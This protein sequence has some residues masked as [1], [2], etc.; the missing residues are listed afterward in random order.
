MNAPS[1]DIKDMLLAESDLGL[2][3]G[4]NLFI[5]KEKTDPDTIVIIYDTFGGMPDLTM[6]GQTFE[7]PSVQIKVRSRDYTI[8]YNLINEIYLLLHGRAHET[9]N[10]TIYE[11]IRAINSPA[12]YDWDDRSRARFIVNFNLQRKQS[13]D[14]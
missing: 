11:L 14:S 1:E 8:G 12:H 10:G 5:G 4:R 9:W 6:D 2:E 7:R 13:A 3:L